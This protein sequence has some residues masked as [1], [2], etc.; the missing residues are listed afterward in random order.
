MPCP[1]DLSGPPDRPELERRYGQV[2]DDREFTR[3]YEVMDVQTPYVNVRRRADGCQGT[4]MFQHEP[5]YYFY[6]ME[7]DNDRR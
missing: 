1:T 5:R 6:F 2:W 4:M 7:D 3:D